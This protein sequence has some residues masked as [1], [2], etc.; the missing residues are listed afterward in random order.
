[1]FL[2]VSAT[3]VDVEMTKQQREQIGRRVADQRLARYGTKSDAYKAAGL[4]AATWDR[5]ESGLSVRAD[6]LA[7]ALRLLW[8][9]TG[10][11]W[12]RVPGN[13][14]VESPVFGSSYDEPNYLQNIEQ[15]VMELQGRI[16]AIEQGLAK[17]GGEGDDRP[18]ATKEPASEPADQSDYDLAAD[19]QGQAIADET[20]EPTEP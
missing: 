13:D 14:V 19:R 15:W 3:V 16:E 20:S 5:I 12:R 2:G 1:M 4:N 7:A 17:K 9:E 8:P 18:S 10:G 6:R 11:D